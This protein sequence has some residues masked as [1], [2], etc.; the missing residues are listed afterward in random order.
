M[1]RF[2]LLSLASLFI[3]I[4]LLSS[5]QEEE[6]AQL[7]LQKTSA[8]FPVAY[9]SSDRDNDGVPDNEDNCPETY[10]PNQADKDKDGKGD[11]CDRTPKV[12]DPMEPSTEEEDLNL[13]DCDEE[14]CYEIPDFRYITM[15]VRRPKPC[16]AGICMTQFA[17]FTDRERG[18]FNPNAEHVVRVVDPNGGKVLTELVTEPS[19]ESL[20]AL[21]FNLSAELSSSFEELVFQVYSNTVVDDE[22]IKVKFEVVVNSESVEFP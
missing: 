18:Y 15:M 5:C 9:K 17:F 13:D 6:A 10:N 8:K 14:T 1:R 19:G 7:S 4:G 21:Q 22:A 20:T 12:H 2:Q 3:A 16:D 11:V